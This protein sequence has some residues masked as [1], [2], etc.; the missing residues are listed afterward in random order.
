MTF[1]QT[2]MFFS[3]GEGESSAVHTLVGHTGQAISQ[4]ALKFANPKI[5]RM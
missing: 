5:G 2:C 3:A 1:G 4:I